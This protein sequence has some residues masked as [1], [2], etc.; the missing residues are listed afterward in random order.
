AGDAGG[1]F[2]GGYAA[3]V[4]APG[5]DEL[6]G[7]LAGAGDLAADEFGVEAVAR[8]HEA[9][10]VFAGWASGGVYVAEQLRQALLDAFED[11]DVVGHGQVGQRFAPPEG[12]LDLGLDVVVDVVGVD[13]QAADQVR[14]RGHAA[15]ARSSP[16]GSSAGPGGR[17]AA[18]SARRMRSS[19]ISS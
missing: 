12:R 1:G 8:W 18:A 10:A 9:V 11:G 6:A 16:S 17:A 4:D 13:A 7:V 19:R 2:G 5:G 14:R 3:Q 15:H